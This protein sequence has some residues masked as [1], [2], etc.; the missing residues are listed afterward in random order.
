MHPADSVQARPTRR[1]PRAPRDAPALPLHP[2]EN[3]AI[4]QGVLQLASGFARA[5]FPALTAEDLVTETTLRLLSSDLRKK[6]ENL[7]KAGDESQLRGMV[8]RTLH[9]ASLDSSRYQ[10]QL[11]RRGGSST[12]FSRSLERDRVPKT[13]LIDQRMAPLQSILRAELLEVL[14]GA[15]DALS[16]AESEVM[17]AFAQGHDH[18]AVARRLGK[19]P[20]SVWRLRLTARNAI[21]GY[22]LAHG[23]SWSD[24]ED[25][26]VDRQL[27]ADLL[28]TSSASAMSHPSN[29]RTA[30]PSNSSSSMPWSSP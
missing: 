7:A 4:W 15:I 13:A 17:T 30:P 8:L 19:S 6:V 23:F 12:A 5:E 25:L 29:W 20:A 21:L 27:V 28:K 10:R 22:L 11:R 9:Q 1:L 3:G 16:G 2:P 26:G 24:L 14:Q 18:T